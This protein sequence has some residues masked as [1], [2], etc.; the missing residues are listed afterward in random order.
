MKAVMAE[1]KEMY[2]VACWYELNGAAMDAEQFCEDIY[3]PGLYSSSQLFPRETLREM[4]RPEIDQYMLDHDL[5]DS[6][7]AYIEF[8]DEEDSMMRESGRYDKWE[9]MRERDLHHCT[10]EQYKRGCDCLANYV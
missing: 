8:L 10:F 4:T 2:R 6:Y 9:S 7:E 5:G 3:C 1:L